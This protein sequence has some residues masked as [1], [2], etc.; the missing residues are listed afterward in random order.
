MKYRKL[1][2]NG[3]YVIG[4]GSQDFYIDIPAVAQAIKTRLQLLYGSFWLDQTDGLPLF[5]SILGTPGSPANLT[6][7]DAIYK[8]RILGTPNV[9]TLE[10]FSS[11]F[12]RQTRQYSLTTSVNTTF[13]TTTV[14][15][16][17]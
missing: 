5:Q 13:G 9:S 11:Q 15:G 7:V 3:D 16:T 2:A 14:Q 17:F 8:N 1:D 6:F 10:N 12:N 4:Q